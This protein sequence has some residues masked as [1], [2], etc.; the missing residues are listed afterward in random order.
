MFIRLSDRDHIYVHILQLITCFI[1]TRNFKKP[2]KKKQ[3][4]K[5]IIKINKT[6]E[7]IQKFQASQETTNQEFRTHLDT[8][9]AH[10]NSE[11]LIE[12]IMEIMQIKVMGEM[13]KRTIEET[14]GDLVTNR[15]E[16]KLLKFVS[17]S[18]HRACRAKAQKTYFLFLWRQAKS[19]LTRM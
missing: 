19:K 13:I 8:L 5:L 15:K 11:H 3:N 7:T 16:H 10:I 1:A 18:C 12:I 14:K 6:L 17:E 2:R 4:T 9:E